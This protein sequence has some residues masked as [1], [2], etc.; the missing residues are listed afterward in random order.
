MFFHGCL[1]LGAAVR[2]DNVQNTGFDV[3]NSSSSV[4]SSTLTHDAV[5]TQCVQN[6][7]ILHG[8]KKDGDSSM[9]IF[10]DKSYLIS[11]LSD[12]LYLLECKTRFI[13]YI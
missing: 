7:V 8:K 2:C 9:L 12:I 11:H 13:P 1:L 10:I 6:Q 4:H 3:V 5:Y